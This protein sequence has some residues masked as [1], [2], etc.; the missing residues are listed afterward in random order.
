VL[1]RTMTLFRYI[2]GK[3][4]FEAFYKKDLSKRLLLDKSAS[5]D[6]EKGM[7]SKL[8]AECGSGFT[9]KLEGMFKDVDLSRDVMTSF[10]ES[11][12]FA[13]I[14]TDVELSVHVLTQ[15]YWPTYPPVEVT[16]PSE[17]S[18]MQEVFN[19]YYTGK[20]NG[21]RLQW[22]PFLG[23]CT[24]RAAFPSGR[25]ELVVSLLQGIILLL[26]NAAERLA[27]SDILA[28]TGM[29]DKELKVTLQSLACGKQRVLRKEPKG[30]DVAETDEFF[31][32][33]SFKHPLF[34]IKINS[35]QMRETEGETE[36]TTERVIQD[37]QYQIDAAIVRTMKARKTLTHSLLVSE[38]FQQ[39]RFPLK[40]PDIKKRIE[41][42][43]DRE[44]LERDPGAS[45]V[46]RYL[47]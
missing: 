30:R 36:Q 26:F 38:L 41:S 18:R 29:E 12:Q 20:H 28:S 5:I 32:D 35:I 11:S 2:D 33:A 23:H 31:Y 15:G 45:S 17:V 47:A 39:L 19:A 1:D 24:I 10:K 43:I 37:R 42:L 46:Y 13:S 4:M 6:A 22:H 44:Y 7:I 16:L 14:P 25:K 9:S 3:D 34:R 8:K 27:Y 21:R 40:P